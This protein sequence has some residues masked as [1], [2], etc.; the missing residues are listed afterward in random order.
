MLSQSRPVD[1]LLKVSYLPSPDRRSPR[2]YV[3]PVGREEVVRGG[4]LRPHF[5]GCRQLGI[6]DRRFALPPRFGLHQ[7][8]RLFPRRRR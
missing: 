4:S 6:C 1:P 3:A 8:H 7:L 2:Q 5:T